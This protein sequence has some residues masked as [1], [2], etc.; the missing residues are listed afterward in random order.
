MEKLIPRGTR[1][2]FRA[3]KPLICNRTA[4]YSIKHTRTLFPWDVTVSY[5]RDVFNIKTLVCFF[6]PCVSCEGVGQQYMGMDE[7]A[8][9]I[10]ENP[11]YVF[12]KR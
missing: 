7:F 8:D 5:A 9:L 12:P 6:G 3:E 11:D 10:E 2:V 1:L 4:C